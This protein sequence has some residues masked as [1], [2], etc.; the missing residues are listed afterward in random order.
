[1]EKESK[2]SKMLPHALYFYEECTGCEIKAELE[3]SYQR[4]LA[5]DLDGDNVINML[6]G[7][8]ND[9]ELAS[10]MLKRFPSLNTV[11]QRYC[12]AVRQNTDE[13]LVSGVKQHLSSELE[14]QV[15]N[16]HYSGSWT[17]MS[18]KGGV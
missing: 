6:L 15:F 4:F 14:K 18:T 3:I 13:V 17:S 16:R 11:L 5:S 12:N 10:V 7:Q 2:L 1:M 9:I 8:I